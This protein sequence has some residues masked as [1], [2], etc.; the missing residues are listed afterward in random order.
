MT[1]DNAEHVQALARGLSVI[2]AF[3]P[4][5]QFMTLTEVAGRTGMTRAA[6]RR[7]LLTLKN[8]GYV[9]N[10]DGKHFSLEPQVLN[11][12]YAYLS[13]IPWWEAAQR[14]MEEVTA[15][16]DE[17]CSAA[18]LDGTD[19]VYVARVS[20][21]RIMTVALGIGT[22]L[23]AHA[24]SMGRVLLAYQDPAQQD[25]YLKTAKLEKITEQTTVQASA[26]KKILA[27]VKQQGYC[28]VDQELERGV[29]SIAVPVF[30]RAGKCLA[31]INVGTHVTRVTKAKLLNKVLPALIEASSKITRTL[32]R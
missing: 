28:I 25:A 31:A 2:R 11:L 21:R 1:K 6:A 22:R 30:D 24:T 4:E 15:A 13:S 26:L 5:H 32:P 19:I 3:G 17:S 7:F 20:T 16:V 12:G 8:L 23:P 10:D 14:Y 9:K 18:V 29:R 27:E